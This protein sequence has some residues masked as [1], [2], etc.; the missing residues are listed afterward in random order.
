MHLGPQHRSAVG[1]TD[2]PHDDYQRVWEASPLALLVID[3]QSVVQSASPA[4]ARMFATDVRSLLGKAFS[5]LVEPMD[6]AAADEMLARALRGETPPRQEIRFVRPD[7][8]IVT[9]GLSIA[10]LEDREGSPALAVIRDLS[11]EQTLRPNLL[12]TEKLASMGAVAATVAHEVNNPLMGASAAL[13]TLRLLLDGDECL[14]LVDTALGEIERAAQIVRDLRQFAR[15]GEETKEPT[16]VA[17][18]LEHVQR[19]HCTSH[20]KDAIVA[21][22]CASDLPTVH[23]VHNHLVQALRNLL[24]NAHQAVAACEPH[25]QRIVLR[26]QRLGADAIAIDV[27]DQGPG[28]PR[29]AKERIFEAFYSTK[30][31][32]EGTGLGLTVV[33]AIAG[34]HGGRIDVLDTQG[35]GA[36]F[37]LVLPIPLE[38]HDGGGARTAATASHRSAALWLP[39][40]MRILL[41]D[42]EPAIRFAVARF[43]ARAGASITV[44]EAADANTAIEALRQREFDAVLLDRRFPGG[45][46]AAVLSAMSATK[47][48]LIG[49]T[50]LMSGALD[51]DVHERLGHAFFAS[52]QKPFDL[53]TLATALRQVHAMPR[54]K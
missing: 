7:G 51:A 23:A 54:A 24:R 18:L 46:D 6:R 37:R 1:M 35:G 42:D 41:V 39:D 30:P 43:C 12:Q 53:A 16:H 10:R 44:V 22:E 27:V 34:G 49:R 13:Q 20:G 32:G 31:A 45:G 28:V 36:T 26:A 19:L 15:R 50:I 17:A 29:D 38:R 33:Q 4:G 2:A 3:S 52:L 40:G 25:R 11:H 5:T 47:P 21:I 8:S 9:G 48:E 14:Q